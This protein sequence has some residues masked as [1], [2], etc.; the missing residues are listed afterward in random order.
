M[1]FELCFVQNLFIF[2]KK[3]KV[4]LLFVFLALGLFLLFS[5]FENMLE[6]VAIF[7]FYTSRNIMRGRISNRRII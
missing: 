2:Q 1:D 6:Y 5:S 3:R 7:N 4:L